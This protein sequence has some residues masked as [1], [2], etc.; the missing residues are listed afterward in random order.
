[1]TSVNK[2]P[3]PNVTV[4]VTFLKLGLVRVTGLAYRPRFFFNRGLKSL[5]DLGQLAPKAKSADADGIFEILVIGLP[6]RLRFFCNRGLKPL[7]APILLRP[8]AI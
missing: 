6:Y 1:M 7:T 8:E 3:K 4:L 2:D 5:Y